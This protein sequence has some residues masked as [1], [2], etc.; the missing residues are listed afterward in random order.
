MSKA[1]DF[2]DGKISADEFLGPAPEPLDYPLDI[3]SNPIDP[4]AAATTAIGAIPPV[5]STGGA[6]AGA[7]AGAATPVPGGALMGGAAGAGLG[8]GVGEYAKNWLLQSLGL[9]PEI[10]PEQNLDASMT[11]GRNQA[12]FGLIPFGKMAAPF[13]RRM[14]P[15]AATVAQEVTERGIPVSPKAINPSL[16]ASTA[17][18]V[19]DWGPGRLWTHFKRMQIDP[20][21]LQYRQEVIESLPGGGPGVTDFKIIA[22]NLKQETKK[23]YTIV[24]ETIGKEGSITMNATHEKVDVALDKVTD[25][26]L[27]ARLEKF[28]QG[29]REKTA[30]QLDEFQKSIWTNLYTKGG[31]PKSQD[32]RIV[33][34]IVEAMKSDMEDFSAKTGKDL[35]SAYLGAKELS[36]TERAMGS[37]R[38][39]FE[40]SIKRPEGLAEQFNPGTFVQLFQ[41]NEKQLQ[42]AL[43]KET[44][45]AIKK[46]ADVSQAVIGDYSQTK[47]MDT[48]VSYLLGAGA[49][50]GTIASPWVAVPSGFSLVMAKSLMNPKGWVN[51][52]LTT[53]FSIPKGAGEMLKLGGRALITNSKGEIADAGDVM[54]GDVK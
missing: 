11:E 14:G 48:A 42:K 49:A 29:G 31:N 35:L 5:L 18:G 44:F 50:G 34:E 19:A 13:A 52:W 46:F 33:G 16:A 54:I 36:K 47:G 24:R 22:E 23:A 32:A 6:I 7:A 45:D 30:T 37:L 10:T 21:M 1:D 20:K 26:Q 28:M 8:G 40:R 12:L 4:K 38:I 51:N 41:K 3:Y 27:R 15:E 17:Q 39:M 2:L 43:P 25:P 53:G 9:G